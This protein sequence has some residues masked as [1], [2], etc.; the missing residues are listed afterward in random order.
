MT[1]R[2]P[3][4]DTSRREL[5]RSLGAPEEAIESL[6]EA[7]RPRVDP[8]RTAEVPSFPFVDEPQLDAW[9]DIAGDAAE[10][11]VW[12]ALSHWFPQL[13]FPVEEG[14]SEDLD[15]VD[16]TRRGRFPAVPTPPRLEA[17]DSVD[18]RLHPSLG[19]TVPVIITGPRTDFETLVRAFTARGEPGHV[20]SS[21]G[22]CMVAGLNDWRRIHRHREAWEAAEPD[23]AANSEAWKA[24]FKRLTADKANYQDRLVLLSRGPYSGVAAGDLGVDEQ[25]WPG[26]SLTI[27]LEHEC[28]HYFTLRAFGGLQHNLHEE[29]LAD[30]VGLIAADD[31]FDASLAL[32]FL[33]LES[34]PDYRRG[35]RLENYMPDDLPEN[36]LPALTA[37]VHAAVL[38]LDRLV[39]LLSHVTSDRTLLAQVIWRL[40]PLGL[41]ELA[42]PKA[43]SEVAAHHG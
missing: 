26:R 2:I 35:G 31:R 15:Y 21:M 4:D 42:D 8:Q 18:L 7:I 39:A 1:R 3:A 20:P 13:M 11:G 32:R 16:A 36:A 41:D 33:G 24:E 29:L 6:V 9:R 37:L 30:L 12:P 19:G 28:T 23:R 17:P 34:Y 27:R 43:I 22:A 25:T 40:T 38:G 5:L 14:I 10:R